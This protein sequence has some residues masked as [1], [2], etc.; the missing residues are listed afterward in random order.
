ML[1]CAFR[2]VVRIGWDL[3]G[4]GGCSETGFMETI[5]VGVGGIVE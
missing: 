5:L 2:L 4:L 1:E 3:V